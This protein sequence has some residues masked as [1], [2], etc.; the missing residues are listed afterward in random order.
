[1]VEMREQESRFGADVRT[2][3]V[4]ELYL[5]GP[6]DKTMPGEE[7]FRPGVV[8]GDGIGGTKSERSG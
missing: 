3:G 8:L 7:V 5:A 6:I 1:M 4:D 2:E